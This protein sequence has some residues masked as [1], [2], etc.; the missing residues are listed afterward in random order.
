VTSLRALHGAG[1]DIAIVVTGADRR[2]GRNQPPSASPVK[3]AALTLGLPVSH[4]VREVTAVGAE[5]GVVVAFGR[6]VKPDVLAVLSMV[7]VHFSLLPRWRGA[8]PVER[9]IL[10]GDPLTGV[11]LMEVEEGLDTGGVFRR[12]EVPIGAHET[13]K[14]LTSRL[15]LLG[16]TLLVDG[17]AEGLGEATPQ[18]GDPTYAAKIDPAELRLDFERP[19]WELERLVRVG[20]AWTTWRDRRL[21]VVDAISEPGTITDLEA[22]PVG[23]LGPGGV[24]ST[25]D[26]VLRLLTVQPEGRPVRPAAEWIMGARPQPGGRLGG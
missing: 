10:A 11:C 3:V 16:A 1:H 17:L 25:A 9:A 23:S 5:L 21:L 14:E 20:R 15:A 24:V 22:L 13:A 6:I 7:N 12:V 8:A 2:R 4:E 26:G 18:S 19:A